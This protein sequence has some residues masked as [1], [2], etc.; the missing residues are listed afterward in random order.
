MGFI[1]IY[2]VNS[3]SF[4][5]VSSLCHVFSYFKFSQKNTF[6]LVGFAKNIQDSIPSAVVCNHLSRKNC[7]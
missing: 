4:V 6:P 1:I 3:K 2:F 5:L 7:L